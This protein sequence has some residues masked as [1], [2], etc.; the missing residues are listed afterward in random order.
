[1]RSFFIKNVQGRLQG[2]LYAGVA[3]GWEMASIG[4][5]FNSG[6]GSGWWDYEIVEDGN[7]DGDGHHRDSDEDADADTDSGM[8]GLEE[9]RQES[10]EMDLEM[11]MEFENGADVSETVEVSPI[12]SDD[13]DCVTADY[14]E[15]DGD[16]FEIE[17]DAD[18]A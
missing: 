8:N 10:D 6:S 3:R 2:V 1:V 16:D 18:E 5:G 4:I 17:V 12:D 15:D 13:A 7:V 9:L 14:L 11:E